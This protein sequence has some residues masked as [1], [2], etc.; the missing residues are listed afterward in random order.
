MTVPFKT[1]R[2]DGSV[3]R[4][5]YHIQGVCHRE[6]G[7]AVIGYYGNGNIAFEEYHIN[8][9]R[10]GIDGPSFVQ[11]RLD[12]SRK[13]ESWYKDG[14]PH[15]EDGPS[16]IRYLRENKPPEVTCFH[17]EGEP[18]GFWEVFNKVSEENQKVLLK[19]W[20]HLLHLVVGS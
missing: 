3:L 17:L 20:S 10:H 8:N 18:L 4:E 2:D 13:F 16:W 5:V 12:G 11:Y 19:D 1:Y 14:K 15:R 6:D 9:K 7:P